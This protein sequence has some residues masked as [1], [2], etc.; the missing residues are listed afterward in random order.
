[1]WLGICSQLWQ[2]NNAERERER[3]RVEEELAAIRLPPLT[4]S[5]KTCIHPCLVTARAHTGVF[6]CLVV[7]PPLGGAQVHPT[8]KTRSV[9]SWLW[10]QPPRCQ[11]GATARISN[12]CASPGAGMRTGHLS[13]P[14]EFRVWAGVKRCPRAQRQEDP[15][16]PEQ[17]ASNERA[18]GPAKHLPGHHSHPLRWHPWVT[19]RSSLMSSLSRG[20]YTQLNRVL[21][22]KQRCNINLY[23]T[24]IHLGVFSTYATL[25]VKT[26]MC[27]SLRHMYPSK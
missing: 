14:A 20:Y 2:D 23:V 11:G 3:E 9:L 18:T 21:D 25:K 1:M 8:V 7:S 10:S 27:A 16:Y 12:R 22:R 13:L 6:I 15:V 5:T 19:S 17:D 26:N 24:D 4:I